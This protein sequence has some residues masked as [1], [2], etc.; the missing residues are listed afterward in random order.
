MC[1]R[2]GDDTAAAAR[3]F[4][5]QHKFHVSQLGVIRVHLLQIN[6]SSLVMGMQSSP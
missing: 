3:A 5:Q 6:D 4:T 2:V 1:A